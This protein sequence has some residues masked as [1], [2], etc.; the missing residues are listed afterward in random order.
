MRSQKTRG[1]SRIASDVGERLS[2]EEL[3]ARFSTPDACV[4]G[5]VFSELELSDVSADG[6][7]F[8]QVIFRGCTLDNVCL[9]NCAFTD[10]LFSGCR[11]TR[12]DMGRSWL[13]RCD[14]RSCST[15]GL[16]FLRGRLT[17]VSTEDSQMSYCDLSEATVDRFIA[18]ETNLAEVSLFSTKLRHVTLDQCDLTRMSVLRTSLA[19]IDLSSCDIS[20]LRVSDTFR[21]LRGAVVSP[22][23]AVQLAGL[24]GVQVKQDE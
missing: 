18:C 17:G 10:V 2:S 23:Q 8:E 9:A 3:L 13:N 5:T 19:G 4:R 20:G 21:E 12:C 22:E 1:F 24:L 14:F 16:S 7:S 15:P 6:T 11:M